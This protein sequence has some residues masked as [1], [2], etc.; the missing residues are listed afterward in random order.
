MFTVNF[1]EVKTLT[2]VLDPCWS[3]VNSENRKPHKIISIRLSDLK[4]RKLPKVKLVFEVDHPIIL[5]D[6][7]L[8]GPAFKKIFFL[9]IKKIFQLFATARKPVTLRMDPRNLFPSILALIYIKCRL[10]C[11]E[12]WSK[13]KKKSTSTNFRV[14]ERGWKGQQLK[15]SDTS[16][17][18]RRNVI[19]CNF[20]LRAIKLCWF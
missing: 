18:V 15:I 9:P 19:K 1:I 16:E 3:L 11:G 14:A 20:T 6:L 5:F 7:Q 10:W 4:R 12:C 13:F 17:F 2:S 8:S